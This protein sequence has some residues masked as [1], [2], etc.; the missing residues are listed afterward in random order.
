MAEKIGIINMLTVDILKMC[1]PDSTNDACR[2]FLNPL[3]I[4]IREFDIITKNQIAMFI[5]QIGHESGSL[6]YVK[7]NLNYSAQGLR[8]VFPKYFL[9]DEIALQYERKPEAIAN[10][11][12]AN[13]MGNGD[14]K[15]GDGWKY[16]GRGL[17]QLTGKT[18]YERTM[19]GLNIS[20]PLY[21]ETPEGASRSAGW[22]WKTNKLN[23]LSEQNDVLKV[24]KVINGGTHGLE[25][26]Q[27]KY[28]NALNALKN[29][30]F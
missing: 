15:S 23:E 21:F 11:V 17:I 9:T 28:D 8:K 24:T 29:V 16:R 3:N 6:K 26:R 7:E 5:A 18:N 14:E 2:I 10:R 30:S 22:F 13:R 4:T 27:Q 20:D 19:K 12:Y 1:L 25:D